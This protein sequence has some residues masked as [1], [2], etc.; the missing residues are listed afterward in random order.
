MLG[1]KSRDDLYFSL[2]PYIKYYCCSCES[3]ISIF[4]HTFTNILMSFNFF[5][6][7][8]IYFISWR[9]TGEPH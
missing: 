1:H 9:H 2:R 6:Y 4:Y 3:T 5:E 7:S 8:E